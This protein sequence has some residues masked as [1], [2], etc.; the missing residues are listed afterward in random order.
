MDLEEEGAAR[1]FN[2][3][4]YDCIISCVKNGTSA[5]G[6]T[7][8]NP[9]LQHAQASIRETIST[10]LRMTLQNLKLQTFPPYLFREST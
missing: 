2:Q 9:P 6:T 8:Q 1:Q 7:R 3:T 5:N 10:A 4:Q